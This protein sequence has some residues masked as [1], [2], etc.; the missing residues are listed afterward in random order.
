MSPRI[1]LAMLLSGTLSACAVGPNYVRPTTAVR[2]TWH[3][4]PQTGVRQESADGPT[5]AS[6]WTVLQDPTLD[7]LVRRAVENNLNVKQAVARVREARARR[8]IATAGL[9]PTIGA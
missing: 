5:L 4:Q 3:A 7:D 2:D 8:Q 9:L 1:W 6:W